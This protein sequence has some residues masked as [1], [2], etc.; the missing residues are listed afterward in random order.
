M[1]IYIEID[2]RFLQIPFTL[3]VCN[4]LFMIFLFRTFSRLRAQYVFLNLVVKRRHL[5][6]FI[7]MN[8]LIILHIIAQQNL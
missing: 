8:L 3:Y 2:C 5:S 4:E 1:E 7:L 6:S